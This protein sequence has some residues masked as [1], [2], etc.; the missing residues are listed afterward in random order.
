MEFQ[1]PLDDIPS[2]IIDSAARAGEKAG[3]NTIIA[4]SITEKMKCLDVTLLLRISFQR[5]DGKENVFFRNGT[6]LDAMMEL[7]MELPPPPPPLND[8]DGRID[9]IHA[10]RPDND[11]PTEKDLECLASTYVDVRRE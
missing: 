9:D 6:F 2:A 1:H 7:G 10:K 11:D 5:E 3:P 4:A 8:A